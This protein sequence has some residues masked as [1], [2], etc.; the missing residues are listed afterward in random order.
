MKRLEGFTAV[1]NYLALVIVSGHKPTIEEANQAV[2][3]LL[4]FYGCEDE[5]QLLNSGNEILI[6]TYN[7][8][9]EKIFSYVHREEELNG[10][11][12]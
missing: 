12:A 8:A 4:Q 3:M 9:K 5:P 2:K 7:Q 10:C 1:N 6:I 11:R